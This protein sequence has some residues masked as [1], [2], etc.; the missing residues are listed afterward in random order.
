[1]AQ[2]FT[3]CEKDLGTMAVD[4]R[5]NYV[6]GQVLGVQDFRQEQL[7]LIHK[8]RVHN[9]TLHGYGTVHGL[10]VS[11]N[12]Q[13]GDALEVEVAPG[14]AVDPLGRE[15]TITA[16]QCALLNIWLRGAAP[17]GQV[18]ADT[19]ERDDAG[20]AIAYITLC[21]DECKT[22]EQPVFGDPC[23]S[24]SEAIQPTRVRDLFRLDLAAAPP[25]QTEETAIRG[26]GEVLGHLRLTGGPPLGDE[27][28]RAILAQIKDSFRDPTTLAAEAVFELPREQA[29]ALLREALLFWVT[30]LRPNLTP[31]DDPCLLLAALRLTLNADKQVDSRDNVL[32]DEAR[33]PYLLQSRLLQE[34]LLLGGAASAGVLS[35]SAT[36]VD[37]PAPASA[38]F[39]PAT[40]NIAFEIPRGEKGDPGDPGGGGGAGVVSASATSVTPSDP[41]TATFDPNTGNI[42]FE[43][44]RG[45]RGVRGPAG[46]VD[47]LFVAPSQMLRVRGD[48]ALTTLTDFGQQLGIDTPPH[49]VWPL[50]P[51][52]S[53]AFN[54][55][56][57][58]EWPPNAMLRLLFTVPQDSEPM[59]S[60]EWRWTRAIPVG[61]GPN[62]PITSLSPGL[63]D[64]LE[65]PTKAFGPVGDELQLTGT[66]PMPLKSHDGE[67]ADYLMVQIT[68]LDLGGAEVL[69]LLM[70]ELVPEG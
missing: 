51:R 33:R 57:G 59:L 39:D 11:L 17:E 30:D 48:T 2:L 3:L 8:N 23:R 4:E 37:P 64:R 13:V 67:P 5:L 32:V 34:W 19:L 66:E 58:L 12:E 22:G 50:R 63:R 14:M 53:V 43:I 1:M 26:I 44:P 45:Q 27:A 52:E 36:T 35:A 47:R 18:I 38:T 68:L 24:D 15:I 29:R 46:I 61:E 54:T 21:Y 16:L 20:R 56:W 42:A 7:Y 31:N 69:G 28:L 41:A 6:F 65:F 49:P 70:A 60:V 9:R 40:G 25:A 10:A 55:G 62:P